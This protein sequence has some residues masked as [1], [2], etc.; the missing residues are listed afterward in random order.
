MTESTPQHQE[1]LVSL[2]QQGLVESDRPP[3]DM[4]DFA[5]AVFRGVPSTQIGLGLLRPSELGDEPR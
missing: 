2:I 4:T 3:A 1:M 5:K